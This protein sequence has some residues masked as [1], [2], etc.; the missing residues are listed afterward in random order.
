MRPSTNEIFDFYC[1][2]YR[3]RPVAHGKHHTNR[4]SWSP[5][6]L[7]RLQA[8]FVHVK[9]VQDVRAS[10]GHAN[11]L[12]HRARNKKH[13]E[14]QAARLPVMPKPTQR[15]HT[16]PLRHWP[17]TR[18]EPALAIFFDFAKAF[19][20]VPHD[21]LIAKLTLVLPPKAAYWARSYSSSSSWISMA[22]FRKAWSWRSTPASANNREPRLGSLTPGEVRLPSLGS[23]LFSESF[24]QY[25]ASRFHAI[26]SLFVFLCSC[27]ANFGKFGHQEH[28]PR[29]RSKSIE[30]LALRF[31]QVKLKL[32]S[33]GY[34]LCW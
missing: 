33:S 24:V 20:R 27:K 17:R 8:Y 31:F 13:D 10:N 29:K 26:K 15:H 28:C 9:R 23:L 21:R 18:P 7:K 16:S 19:D 6:Q 32:N 2:I 22:T 4:K 30:S 14:E 12:A 5:G 11:H 1:Q 25:V 3:S 34:A